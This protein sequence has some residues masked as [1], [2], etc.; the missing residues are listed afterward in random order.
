MATTRPPRSV[1]EPIAADRALLCVR[2][3]LLR[4]ILLTELDEARRSVT[5]A[6][7]CVGLHRRGF[8][9][10]GRP[11]KV[12]SDALRCEVAR[13]R[14]D[15]TG[16][17]RYRIGYLPPTTRWR[18]RH[19][20]QA[21]LAG[22]APPWHLRPTS[23]PGAGRAPADPDGAG[24]AD[25]SAGTS[26]PGTSRADAGVLRPLSREGGPGVTGLAP[27]V[28]HAGVGHAAAAPTFDWRRLVRHETPL[29]P[30]RPRR[31]HRDRT[32]LRAAERP[33]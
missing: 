20:M 27:G 5:V 25:S 22:A 30:A 2:G 1:L 21:A 8:T 3:L 16:R 31:G 28:G 6:Q 14:V 17:G 19:R 23:R 29:R 7:L 33:P 26:L 12:V 18:C 32:R 9:V 4:S 13:G 11:G 15:R 10:A 24:P